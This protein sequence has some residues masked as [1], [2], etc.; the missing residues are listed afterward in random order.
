MSEL[1]NFLHRREVVSM[2]SSYYLSKAAA[3]LIA[4]LP[5]DLITAILQNETW[6]GE[7]ISLVTAGHFSSHNAFCFELILN[8]ISNMHTEDCIH[9]FTSHPDA[10]EC[11]CKH[12]DNYSMCLCFRYFM[13][14]VSSAEASPFDIAHLI[15]ILL[16]GLRTFDSSDNVL[17]LINLLL[18]DAA[19]DD[20]LHSQFIRA[21]CVSP[22]L[23]DAVVAAIGEMPALLGC[24]KLQRRDADDA[25]AHLLRVAR[26]V[27]STVF[28]EDHAPMVDE[29]LFVQMQEGDF[30]LEDALRTPLATA[31]LAHVDDLLAAM[32]AL[33]AL[34]DAAAFCPKCFVEAGYVLE[35]LLFSLNLP[36]EAGEVSLEQVRRVDHVLATAM[37]TF[38]RASLL[39]GRV[40]RIYKQ[41]FKRAD[42]PAHQLIVDASEIFAAAVRMLEKPALPAC[43]ALKN[44]CRRYE[45]CI[46]EN[47]A[48]REGKA[49]AV[50]AEHLDM[51]EEM[52]PLQDIDLESNPILTFEQRLLQLPQEQLLALLGCG[53]QQ[54]VSIIS[55]LQGHFGGEETEEEEDHG[56]EM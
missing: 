20:G 51:A 44:I 26:R 16:Q 25:C 15:D 24:S 2:S 23:Q 18:A 11:C 29:D 8:R 19:I 31:L 39:H 35:V 43:G 21:F 12:L 55:A 32:E 14:C 53:D 13:L 17:A 37:G 22:A 50:V 40:K 36:E 3:E 34:E 30:R 1:M 48:L 5:S 33:L 4:S 9:F 6:V 42:L 46:K 28:D 38:T 7:I 49:Y 52:K 41:F 27:V 45:K 56:V 54:L 47:P 10:L